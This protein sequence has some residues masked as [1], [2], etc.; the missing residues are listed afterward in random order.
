MC[1][2]YMKIKTNELR[3]VEGAKP[4]AIQLMRRLG[5]MVSCW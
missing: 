3:I 4:E 5:Y 1:V 2:L